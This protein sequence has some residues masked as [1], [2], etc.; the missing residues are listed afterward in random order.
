[1]MVQCPWC[2]SEVILDDGICPECRH[3]VLPEH[4]ESSDFDGTMN[5]RNQSNVEHLHI[6]DLVASK[7]MCR[8]CG[9]LECI[10]QEVSMSGTGV[11]KIFDINYNHY[12]F[13]SC[14]RCGFVEVINPDVLRGHKSGTLETILD[15]IWR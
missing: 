8:R 1:M 7:F 10:T 2:A 4:L 14:T 5:I 12:L 15:F 6:E 11:S 13:V 9:H 3:E